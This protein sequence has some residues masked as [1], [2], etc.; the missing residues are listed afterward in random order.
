MVDAL[1]YG[2]RHEFL[3]QYL[4]RGSGAIFQ[5]AKRS[6]SNSF[7]QLLK[8]RSN[9]KEEA[10]N[11][12]TGT[13]GRDLSLPVGIFLTDESTPTK[14]AFR[15]DM[16]GGFSQSPLNG[17]LSPTDTHIQ[18]ERADSMLPLPRQRSST[19]C[20]SY[21]ETIKK[22]LKDIQKRKKI[23]HEDEAILPQKTDPP[24]QCYL[25][26]PIIEKYAPLCRLSMKVTLS[27]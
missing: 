14:Q 10:T 7:D 8:R 9:P 4:D 13:L 18:V 23:V 5:K 3:N 11:G 19:L 6:L 27:S 1:C 15:F 16:S 12:Q 24:P 22:E 26:P 20:S 25:K 17:P 21:G 2:D